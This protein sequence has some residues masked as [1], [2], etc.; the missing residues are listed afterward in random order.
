MINI[1]SCIK[2]KQ[3]RAWSDA[4]SAASD[5]GLH[6]LPMSLF[7]TL[8]LNGF[9]HFIPTIASLPKF[10]LLLTI[11]CPGTFTIKTSLK[12]KFGVKS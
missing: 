3:C 8:A 4:A 10:F 9:I 12:T 5:L 6:C 2:C 7:G 1:N 11:I